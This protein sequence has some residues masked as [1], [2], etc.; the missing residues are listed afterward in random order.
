M[1]GGGERTH[2]HVTGTASSR[3]STLVGPVLI[4]GLMVKHW[5]GQRQGQGSEK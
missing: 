2:R 4:P 5:Q 1:K 3:E